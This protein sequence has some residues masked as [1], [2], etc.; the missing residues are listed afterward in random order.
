MKFG[1]LQKKITFVYGD[2]TQLQKLT[3]ETF[4]LV[5]STDVVEHLYPEQLEQMLKQLREQLTNEARVY[6]H[7]APNLNFYKYGYPLIRFFYP[8]IRHLPP[9]RSLIETKDN[10]K[11][12]KRLPKDPEE[13]SHNKLGHVNEQTPRSLK[14]TLEKCGYNASVNVVPFLRPV[15]GWKITFIYAVLSLPGIKHAFSADIIAIATRTFKK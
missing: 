13:G 11:G 5:F 4:T 2:A 8:V 14:K 12:R 3:K 10:W 9:V 15:K 1:L 7:T 6:L